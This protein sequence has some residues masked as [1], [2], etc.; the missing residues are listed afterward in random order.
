MPTSVVAIANLFLRNAQQ[1]GL[2]AAQALN[3]IVRNRIYNAGMSGNTVITALAT[4][5]TQRVE[6]LNGLTRARRPDLPAGSPVKFD[7][8]SS[9]NPLAV[10]IGT[11]ARNIIGFTPDN[12]GDEVGPGTITLDSSMTTTLRETVTT[13]DASFIVTPGGGTN[14]DSVGSGDILRL[15]DIRTAVARMRQ[16]N[17]PAFS[18]MRYHAH[19]DPAAEAELFQDAEIQRLNTAL[20][21]YYMYKDFA[22]GEIHGCVMYRNT[23][24]PQAETVEGG[25]TDSFDINDPFGGELFTGGDNTGVPVHRTL[26]LGM[27]GIHEYY[28]ELGDLVTE[29][30]VTG[31][32]GS[33]S[34]DNNGIQVSTD[35]IQLIL[36]APLN[37]L[38]DLV[39]TSWK[40]IGDWPFR[41]DATTGDSARYKRAV[42]IQH[43]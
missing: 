25:P 6:R 1:L 15:Q 12:P 9:S 30:G 31:K 35:R 3:R 41:T 36:R 23:E 5:A 37:R 33:F 7:L 19:L 24:C 40:F 32:T 28:K 42:V 43:A 14:V 11:T 10:T 27:G 21:D 17:V 4:S 18:D 38:Q 8:V 29:A 22:I 20:P 26:V 39:S 16:E 13:G 34:I 2:S